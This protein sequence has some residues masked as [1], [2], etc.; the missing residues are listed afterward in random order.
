MFALCGWAFHF[1]SESSRLHSIWSDDLCVSPF[2]LLVESE[3][4]G[5]ST[6]SAQEKVEE[7]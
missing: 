3:G 2:L 6:P 4:S 1:A 7:L 5:C